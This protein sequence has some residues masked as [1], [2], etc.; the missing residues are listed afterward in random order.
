MRSNRN[1]YNITSSGKA[2][3]TKLDLRGEVRKLGRPSIFL[4]GYI[5]MVNVMKDIVTLVFIS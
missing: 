5:V 2:Q 1:Q 3:I 4:E